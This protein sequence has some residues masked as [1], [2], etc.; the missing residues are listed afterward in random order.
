MSG[1]YYDNYSN[2]LTGESF[3]NNIRVFGQLENMKHMSCTQWITGIGLNNW[4]D[5]L[6]ALGIQSS[7]YSNSLFFSI[8][9]FGIV[10]TIVLIV[11]VLKASNICFPIKDN[12]ISFMFLLLLLIVIFSDQVLFNR[13]LLY[14]LIW[15]FSSRLLEA[16]EDSTGGEF[17][18]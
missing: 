7:N 4:R 11:G 13:N 5:Y 17:Y 2:K 9:S 8:I 3:Q 1:N 18:E 14:L 10:G 15:L 12:R 6:A 16:D